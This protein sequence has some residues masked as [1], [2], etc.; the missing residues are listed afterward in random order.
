MIAESDAHEGL[1][2]GGFAQA[3]RASGR[4]V[5][6]LIGNERRRHIWAISRVRPKRR[7]PCHP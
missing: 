6:R 1:E 5:S 2:K 4:R 7:R 3:E